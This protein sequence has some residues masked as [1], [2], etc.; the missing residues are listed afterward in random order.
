MGDPR[1]FIE[2]GPQR[3]QVVVRHGDKGMQPQRL[4]QLVVTNARRD[5]GGGANLWR[6]RG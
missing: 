3:V 2:H 5:D 4:G 6:Y 1:G